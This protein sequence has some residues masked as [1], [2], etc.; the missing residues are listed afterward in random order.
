MI[1]VFAHLIDEWREWI[2][3]DRDCLTPATFAWTVGA[4]E[5]DGVVRRIDGRSR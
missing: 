4:L 5:V 3:S 2:V 1:V